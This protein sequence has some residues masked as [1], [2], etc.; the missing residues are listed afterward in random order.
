V[1]GE[2]K[3]ISPAPYPF[4]FAAIASSGQRNANV[5]NLT[6]LKRKV[7]PCLRKRS[8]VPRGTGRHENIFHA[9]GDFS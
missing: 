5:S 1:L 9:S 3:E 2:M 8:R 4:A 7:N 6:H